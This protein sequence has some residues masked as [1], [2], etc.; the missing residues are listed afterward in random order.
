MSYKGR[1]KPHNLDKYVGNPLN[2]IYR[3]FI[4]RL[5]YVIH[6][7]ATVLLNWLFSLCQEKGEIMAT[8]HLLR[9]IC[10]SRICF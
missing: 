6:T 4:N 3:S 8:T 7:N 9:I 2:I 5:A 10:C 1:F